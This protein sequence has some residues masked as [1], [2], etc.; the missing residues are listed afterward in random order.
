MMLKLEN[1]KGK[2][3]ENQKAKLQTEKNR[4]QNKWVKKRNVKKG[5]QWG[6]NGLVHL[7]F[8]AFILLVR[9][10]FFGY[11]AVVCFFPGKKQ[12]KCR[13]KANRKKTT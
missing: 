10:V 1:K 2:H 11:V 13:K 7:H 9:L 8:F 4:K 6:K 12:N 3:V 5:N